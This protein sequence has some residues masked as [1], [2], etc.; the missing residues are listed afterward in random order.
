MKYDSIFM[1]QLYAM[2]TDN[3]QNDVYKIRIISGFLAR[4]FDQNFAF[5]ITK[6][7]KNQINATV[8]IL[9]CCRA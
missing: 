8:A 6:L 2:I 1:Y 5:K 7:I 9:M 3:L 4:S